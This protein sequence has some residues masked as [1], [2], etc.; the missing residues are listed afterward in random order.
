MSGLPGIAVARLM[1][2]P[3]RDLTSAKDAADVLLDDYA[4]ML[5]D[6]LVAQLST[7]RADVEAAIEDQG[8]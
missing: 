3:E 5:P 7:F 1:N 8:N 4:P 2:F 6:R